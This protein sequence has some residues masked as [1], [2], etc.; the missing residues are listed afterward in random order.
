MLTTMLAFDYRLSRSKIPAAAFTRRKEE[1]KMKHQLIIISER[2]AKCSC[3]SFHIVGAGSM[4]EHMQKE[5][6]KHVQ[7]K[8]SHFSDPAYLKAEKAINRAERSTRRKSGY[9]D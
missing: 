1:R 6:A 5:H 2:E 8:E 4:V 7:F 9:R 3:G